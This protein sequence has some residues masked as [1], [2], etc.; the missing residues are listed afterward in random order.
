MTIHN[1]HEVWLSFTPMNIYPV[2]S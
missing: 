1:G 2:T